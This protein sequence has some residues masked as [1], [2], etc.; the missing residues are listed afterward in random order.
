VREALE[1]WLKNFRAS[2]AQIAK[3]GFGDPVTK[4]VTS[5][6]QSSGE[7]RKVVISIFP[8][9][10][11]PE[12]LHKVF[13]IE[14][15]P[16]PDTV[17]GNGV[18]AGSF[19]TPLCL[20]ELLDLSFTLAPLF[21]RDPGSGEQIIGS[22]EE[23]RIRQGFLNNCP[24]I[25]AMV[26]MVHV[27]NYRRRLLEMVTV[28]RRQVSSFRRPARYEHCDSPDSSKAPKRVQLGSSVLYKVQF[29]RRLTATALVDRPTFLSTIVLDK[30]VCVSGALYIN[31]SI[32]S[33]H[34]IHYA[35]M[36]DASGLQDLNRLPIWPAIIEKAYAVGKGNNSYDGIERY[37]N[38]REFEL[39]QECIDAGGVNCQLEYGLPPDEVLADVAGPA[40][41]FPTEGLNN[42]QLRTIL[43]RHSIRPT[44]VAT[45]GNLPDSSVLPAD[46][47]VAVIDTQTTEVG[48]RITVIDALDGNHHTFSLAELRDLAEG[49]A[50]TKT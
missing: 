9:V 10:A 36:V 31:K 20:G 4:L 24:L 19:A 23:D 33:Q 8:V 28:E 18:G 37:V 43:N 47:A 5:A 27:P 39:F 34:S 45:R 42:A 6:A 50:Q 11:R 12:I 30:T 48:F 29:R 21:A 41:F 3:I 32:P 22:D 7:D 1:G 17:S 38:R 16:L 46:H 35:H 13:R 25:A 40:R 49:I 44:L 2:P 15:E 14:S 26:A